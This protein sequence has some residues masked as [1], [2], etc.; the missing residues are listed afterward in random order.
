MKDFAE[1]LKAFEQER[2]WV[3]F[4]SAKNLAMSL[5]V[6]A[7][8][9]VEIFQWLTEE[10]TDNLDPEK[11]NKVKNEMGDVLICLVK[12]S[13]RL[14]IDPLRAARDK[15]EEIKNK[16]PVEK[17]KGKSKKYSDYD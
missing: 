7:S 2:D 3:Q 4:H 16:Y 6:E 5:V 15:L 8:E 14:E 13:N 10:E 11:L 1:D 9:I 17:V 12:L